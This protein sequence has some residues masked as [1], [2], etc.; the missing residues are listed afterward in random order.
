MKYGR[1]KKIDHLIGNAKPP[2]LLIMFI[3]D[4]KFPFD[5]RAKLAF[6][7]NFPTPGCRMGIGVAAMFENDTTCEPQ[8]VHCSLVYSALKKAGK[9]NNKVNLIISFR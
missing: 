4:F 9:I 2:T 3:S 5:G 6:K 8:S 7:Y 1:E